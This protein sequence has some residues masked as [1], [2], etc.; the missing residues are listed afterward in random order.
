M[1]VAS[2][3]A[4][5][6]DPGQF[7]EWVGPLLGAL[8]RAEPN[9]AHQAIADLEAAGCLRAII[10]QNIDGLHQRAGSREVLELHGNLSHAT[11]LSCGAVIK[12]DAVID[13]FLK[14]ERVARCAACGGVMKPNV[15]FIGESLPSDVVS[16]S[17]AHL[18]R[19]DVLL[20]AGSSLEMAP[21]SELPLIVHERGGHLVVVNL[22]PTYLDR[23]ASVVIRGD[24][25]DVLPRVAERC[26]SIAQ[27]EPGDRP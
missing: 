18:R 9:A 22:A 12:T 27:H 3:S 25:V 20:V 19:A 13:E 4:F 7:Y 23:A 1:A 10:T 17:L 15:V 26:V 6:R 21:A 16:A 11:C 8:R 14:S 5:R 2:I 24:V